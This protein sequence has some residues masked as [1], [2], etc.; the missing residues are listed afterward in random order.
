MSERSAGSEGSAP[1]SK[2]QPQ[3]KYVLDNQLNP[4]LAGA[5]RLA[6]W[7]VLSVNELFDVQP[8]ESIPDEV[9]IVY[10]GENEHPFRLKPNTDFG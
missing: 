6:G 8:T 1:I 10:F 7:D 9:I 2:W 5:L 4:K 3:H